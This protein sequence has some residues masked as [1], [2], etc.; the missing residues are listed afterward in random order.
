LATGCAVK[1]DGK[2][3]CWGLNSDSHLAVEVPGMVGV[4]AVA[5]SNSVSGMCA[6]IQGG[7]VRC[8]PDSQGEDVDIAVDAPA[9][10]VAMGHAHACAVL[11]GGT[12]ECWGQ[13]FSGE[14]G[15]GSTADTAIGDLNVPSAVLGIGDAISVSAADDTTC[16]ALADGTVECWGDNTWG[17]LGDGTTPTSAAPVTVSGL[18]TAV[19]VCTG[20]SFGCAALADGSVECWGANS[21]GQL[22][23]GTLADSST[24]VA[25]TGIASARAITCGENHACALL[26]DDSIQCWGADERALGDPDIT[27]DCSWD[28]YPND[29]GLSFQAPCSGTPVPA[30]NIGKVAAIAGGTNSTCALLSDGSAQCWG[31]NLWGQLGDG[32]TTDSFKPVTVM[33]KLNP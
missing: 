3:V 29:S 25:V 10:A 7:A 13:N 26:D 1:R 27:Q 28:V 2:V 18:T 6:V 20:S 9:V 5:T 14:L 15:T 8:W 16:A 12:I 23:D 21:F 24:P 4:T 19:A 30:P 31:Y 32:S 17:E 33:A 22:G 11:E